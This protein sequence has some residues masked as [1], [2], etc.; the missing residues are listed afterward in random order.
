LEILL[1]NLGSDLL[2]DL[3]QSL[4]NSIHGALAFKDNGPTGTTT[5]VDGGLGSPG[6]VAEDI[7]ERLLKLP[8]RLHLG[9]S[10]AKLLQVLSREGHDPRHIQRLSCLAIGHGGG[11]GGLRTPCGSGGGCGLRS[12]SQSREQLVGLHVKGGG[13]LRGGL[14]GGGRRCRFGGC[15]RLWNGSRGRSG[16]GVVDDGGRRGVLQV[17]FIHNV[18]NSGLVGLVLSLQHGSERLGATIGNWCLSSHDE[19]DGIDQERETGVIDESR[20]GG[21]LRINLSEL[22]LRL[23][24]QSLN[25]GRR[26]KRTIR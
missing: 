19:R 9:R 11:G 18:L 16:C 24:V 6:D 12:A 8:T 7:P 5:H 4:A 3:S 2:G 10:Q 23:G 15:R 17:F 13:L 20:C 25:W 21:R 1:T 14:R 22:V 26:T